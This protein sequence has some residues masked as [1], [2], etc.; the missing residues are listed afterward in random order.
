MRELES[1]VFGYYNID[2]EI[3]EMRKR[4]WRLLNSIG[5]YLKLEHGDLSP[6][7]FAWAIGSLFPALFCFLSTPLMIGFF[8]AVSMVIL[9][10]NRLSHSR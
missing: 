4:K 8:T 5:L 2:I 9:L 10:Q 6:P 1:S 3:E 7:A